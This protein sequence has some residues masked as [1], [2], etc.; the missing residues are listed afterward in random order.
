MPEDEKVADAPD[1]K[2]AAANR[3]L[4]HLYLAVGLSTVLVYASFH[5]IDLGFL[6]WFALVPFLFF[7]LRETETRRVAAITSYATTFLYHVLGL[8]WISLVTAPGWIATSFLEGFYTLGIV[9][10]VRWMRARTRLPIAVL[11]PPL[12]VAGE[13][14]RGAHLAFISF[15]WLYM[16]HT[17]HAHTNLIQIADVTSIYGISFLVVLVNAVILDLCFLVDTRNREQKDLSPADWKR[18][19]KLV[20]APVVLLLVANAYGWVRSATVEKNIV[21]GPRILAVQPDLVQDVHEPRY[22]A[23]EIAQ[24]NFD[25]TRLA[26][27]Q[28]KEQDKLPDAILWSETI[29]PWPLNVEYPRTDRFDDLM[30]RWGEAIARGR[31]PEEPPFDAREF[32]HEIDERTAE[33]FTLAKKVNCDFIFGAVDRGSFSTFRTPFAVEHNSV[34]QIGPVA[35]GSIA[36]KQRYDKIN[37][38]PAS[39]GIPGQGSALFGWFYNLVKLMVPDG[40][41]TFERGDGPKL[42]EL[43]HEPHW[44]I[45]VDICFEVSF[46]EL[47]RRGTAEG[48][49]V[50]VCPSN[51]GWF[52]TK[53]DIATAEIDMALDHAK[54]RAIENRR[55]MVRVVNRG[56]TCF[57]DPL[58]EVVPGSMV[59]RVR[60]GVETG[61]HVEGSVLKTVPTSKLDSFYVSFGDVFA[62]LTVLASATLVGISF[63]ARSAPPGPEKPPSS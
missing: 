41:T 55:G 59:T 48:A 22:T 19:G 54:L 35:D 13:F 50:L 61:L 49:D 29:W 15:P 2:A 38:V 21:P 6:A 42:M 4:L 26:L 17:Q 47:L 9:L 31:T 10:L 39:E 5:P 34:Y 11:L 51:D 30:L 63:R 32:V 36:V 60:N 43:A 7:A 1:V 53:N 28:V 37:L 27:A 24:I 40:F 56:I 58:G 12:W 23:R 57:V 3:H 33:L 14:S 18:V 44:K 45:S 52:H 16:G 25:L 62:W 20:G 8:S 46:P